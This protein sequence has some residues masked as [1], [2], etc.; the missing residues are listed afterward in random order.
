MISWGV[1]LCAMSELRSTRS[2][3]LGMGATFQFDGFTP[4]MHVISNNYFK[5]VYPNSLCRNI[6]TLLRFFQKGGR[7]FFPTNSRTGSEFRECLGGGHSI[8]NT[9]RVVCANCVSNSSKLVW[10]K[11]V[12]LWMLMY[13]TVQDIWHF[14]TVSGSLHSRA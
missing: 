3:S 7:V 11:G 2:Q 10:H 4:D 6:L 8:T 14:T 1:N 12:H 13:T 9:S 5:N